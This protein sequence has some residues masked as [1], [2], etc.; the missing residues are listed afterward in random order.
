MITPADQVREQIRQRVGLLP[1]E[2]WEHL[3]DKGVV[4]DIQRGRL[5]IEQGAARAEEILR[6]AGRYVQ[7]SED[8]PPRFV[9]RAGVLSGLARSQRK[10]SLRRERHPDLRQE[11]V[12]LV[13]AEEAA[14]E[15][16]VVAFRREYVGEGLLPWER[17][18]SWIKRQAKRDGPAS[19]WLQVL[20]PD[21]RKMRHGFGRHT[22]DRPIEISREQPA[23]GASWWALKY[24]F[25]D[26]SPRAVHVR[27][28]GVLDQLRYLSERLAKR[29]SWSETGAVLFV[30]TGACPLLG[31]VKVNVR[32]VDDPPA[33][34]RIELVVDPT[35]KPAELAERYVEARKKL[36]SKRHRTQSK[37]HLT[38]AIFSTMRP[39]GQKLKDQLREWNKQYG[40]LGRYRESDVSNFGKDVRQARARLLGRAAGLEPTSFE[41]AISDPDLP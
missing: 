27:Y 35:V 23:Q 7:R 12:S 31:R 1:D 5:T 32:A 30:L 14:A 6:R 21:D 17:V 4:A 22:P 37:K 15:P 34:S 13:M 33:C 36:V 10:P 41:R 16:G 40:H 24:A 19:T 26:G 9:D 2:T 29:Y 25:P 11:A 38:L 18:D 39:K 20:V 8:E 28:G 3:C